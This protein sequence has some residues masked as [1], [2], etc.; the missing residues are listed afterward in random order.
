VASHKRRFSVYFYNP[1]TYVGV[2][3]A[4]GIFIAEVFL[5]T[6]DFMAHG[7]NQYLGLLTYLLLPP[8]LILGLLLIAL[9][10][11]WHRGRILRGVA[12]AKP[13]KLHF[14][15]TNPHHRNMLFVFITGTV[16]VFLMTAVGTYKG[17]HYTES[18]EFCGVLCHGVMNPEFTTYNKS[19]HARVSCVECHIGGG[20]DWYVRSKLSGARQVVRYVTNTYDK[21]I[22]TP[23]HDLRPSKDT[24]EQCHWPEKTYNTYDFRRSYFTS[25]SGAEP[26]HLRMMLQVGG[27]EGRGG[28]HAHMNT[29]ND[30]YYVADDD[31]RQEIS[32]VKSVDK[33]GRE[34][35]YTTEDSPYREAAPP[36]EKIRKMDCIDCHNRPT[37]HYL[38]PVRLAND[39]LSDGRIDPQ[40]P[41]IK[42]RIV[43]A[44]E[45]EYATTED[46]LRQIP[47][48]LV[49]YY[50]KNHPDYYAQN[51]AKISAAADHLKIMFQSNIFPE[52]K[53]RWSAYPDN[54]GHLTSDGCFRCHD[55]GHTSPAGR[56]ITQ[57]CN[58]CH[59]II[60]QGASDSIEKNFDGL[61]FRHP[62]DIDD[63][64][65]ENRCTDCHNGG[66]I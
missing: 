14:D 64:W 12:S 65:K 35:V 59:V 45:Y 33:S 41:D 3:L 39:A 10:A 40:I 54:I 66:S 37:H 29:E 11:V 20:A 61:E 5:F 36:Q 56:A 60:E 34:V 28:V 38:E 6:I 51:S 26:W 48:K 43:D 25:E 47:K 32:W 21:P 42:A 17:F 27:K 31:R 52:M 1:V 44:L 9:G 22:K 15:A 55:G 18:V 53:A 30:I 19:P 50:V 4:L 7:H 58:A 23:V 57:D 63:D 49:K 13:H 2:L 46:A 8:F 16:V 24:C 62:V